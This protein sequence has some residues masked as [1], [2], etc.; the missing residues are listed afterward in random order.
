M[1][2]KPLFSSELLIGR[3]CSGNIHLCFNVVKLLHCSSDIIP[4]QNLSSYLLPSVTHICSFSLSFS[5]FLLNFFPLSRSSLLS[6]A[7][8]LPL[9]LFTSSV[10]VLSS[11]TSYSLVHTL[12]RSHILSSSPSCSPLSLTYFFTFF[13]C[14]PLSSVLFLFLSLPFIRALISRQFL[15]HSLSNFISPLATSVSHS[16]SYRFP[17]SLPFS[18]DI[19]LSCSCVPAFI[20]SQFILP[21]LRLV[22]SPFLN[23]PTS[24]FVTLFS[25][26]S[27]SMEFSHSIKLCY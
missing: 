13:L 12:L 16:L 27:L 19:F 18:C 7:L 8:N 2:I 3:E 14:R 10:R 25:D 11:A 20:L 22:L 5:D 6:F 9:F 17:A 15:T 23:F 26:F 1:F 4:L 24:S 21:L